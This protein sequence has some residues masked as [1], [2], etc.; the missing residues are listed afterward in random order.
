MSATV[1]ALIGAAYLDGG[2][3]GI[4]SARTVMQALGLI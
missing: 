1:E 3:Q 4:S 2:D